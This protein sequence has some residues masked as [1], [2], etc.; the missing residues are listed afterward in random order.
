MLSVIDI[1]MNSYECILTELLFQV[2]S[3]GDEV[4]G[5]TFNSC[6]TT[7]SSEDILSIIGPTQLRYNYSL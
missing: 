1:L 2:Q 5:I 4:S 6:V 3:V 7:E